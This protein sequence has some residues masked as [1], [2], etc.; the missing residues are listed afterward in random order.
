MGAVPGGALSVRAAGRFIL[1]RFA[2]WSGPEFSIRQFLFVP[3][4]MMTARYSSF[5]SGGTGLLFIFT[6]S[7]GENRDESDDGEHISYFMC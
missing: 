1:R 5:T 3:R 7:S 2:R 6:W 4:M